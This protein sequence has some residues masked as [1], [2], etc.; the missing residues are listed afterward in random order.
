MSGDGLLHEVVNS[1]F[2][3]P[4]REALLKAGLTIGVIP[5]GTSNGLFKALVA[6]A[7]EKATVEIAAYIIARGRRMQMDLTEI[8][9]EY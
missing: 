9:A 1:L 5:G 3:N 4:E 6:E 7:N 2:S 8:E